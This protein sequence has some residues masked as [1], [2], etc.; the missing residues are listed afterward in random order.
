MRAYGLVLAQPFDGHGRSH[1]D[2]NQLLG[3][4][5]LGLSLAL[6]GS[7]ALNASYAIR[8]TGSVAAAVR[9]L[10]HRPSPRGRHLAGAVRAARAPRGSGRGRRPFAL[11]QRR[12]RLVPERLGLRGRVSAPLQSSGGR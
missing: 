4:L 11:S 2:A 12:P 3:H 1:D 7:V 10:G 5:L 8:H 9:V 6:L